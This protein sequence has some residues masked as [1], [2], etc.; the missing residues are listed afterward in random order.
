MTNRE[1]AILSLIAEQPRYG[2]Q[3]E[4]VIE[5][6]GMRDWTDVG[7][8]SIY[9][10]LNKLEKDGLIESRLDPGSGRGP[11]RKVYH[12]TAGGRQAWYAAQLEA[13]STPEPCHP[14]LQIA[15]SNLPAVAPQEAV[16]AL[17]IYHARLQELQAY[18]DRRHQEQSPLPF[19]VQ[20]MFDLSQSLLQAQARWIAGF[21]QQL[22]KGI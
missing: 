9:Y 14:A 16:S 8:S 4:G 7:F 10:L 20:A 5:T 6:R 12:L 1:F 18:L 15:L 11:S 22:E 17:Q 13:L 2:Y 3:I 19:H 21:I